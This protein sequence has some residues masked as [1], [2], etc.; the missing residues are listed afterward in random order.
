MAPYGHHPDLASLAEHLDEPAFEI[1]VRDRQRAKLRQ[2]QPRRIGQLQHRPVTQAER[3]LAV[4]LH[5]RAC[6]I[7]VERVRQPSR[8][9]RRAHRPS[10]ITGHHRLART[11]IEERAQRREPALDGAPAYRVPVSPRDETPHHPGIDRGPVPYPHRIDI[12]GEYGEVA[13]IPLYG[14]RRK[15]TLVSQVTAEPPDPFVAARQWPAG[16]PW[17]VLHRRIPVRAA[18]RAG[19][20]GLEGAGHGPLPTPDAGAA[21][22]RVRIVPAGVFDG[23]RFGE[24]AGAAAPQVRTVPSPLL[25]PGPTAPASPCTRVRTALSPLPPV[26]DA[27]GGSAIRALTDRSPRR[28]P[29]PWV[30]SSIPPH[31]RLA[32]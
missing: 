6:P 32:T 16:V 12:P 27:P 5:Q 11:E 7:R 1:D 17:P 30:R 3:I 25:P 24:T 4:E 10:R 14:M 18:S 29:M 19:T 23:E 22:F 26:R 15:P 9:L 21:A 13:A 8:R 2:A 20:P 31:P 28:R